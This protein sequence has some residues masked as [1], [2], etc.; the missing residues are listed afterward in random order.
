[1]N[2]KLD[3]NSNSDLLLSRRAIG[4]YLRKARRRV[5]LNPRRLRLSFLYPKLSSNL[6]VASEKLDKNHVPENLQ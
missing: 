5:V 6:N 2:A 4:K 1:M 3:S